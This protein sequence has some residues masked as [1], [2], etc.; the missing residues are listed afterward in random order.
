MFYAHPAFGERFYLRLL[1]NIV[2]GPK[3]Y[4]NIRTVDG[5]VY[6][7]YKETCFHR[8]LLES[9]KEWHIALADASV[10][11]SASQFRDLFVTLL[12]FCEVS[13]PLELW[14]SHWVDMADDIEYTRHKMT[15]FPKLKIGNA[16][17]EMLALEAVNELLKQYGKKV[18]DYPGLP[19]LRV[20]SPT[21]YKNELLM[22]KMMYDREELRLKA[23]EGGITAHSRFKIPIDADKFSC[24]EIKQ[25]TYLAELICNTS[26]VIW[27]EAPMT[28]RYVFEAVDRTFRD[29][30]SKVN[31]E[32]GTLPFGGLTM[33]LGGDFRQV[34]PVIPKKRRV[35]IVAASISKSDLL[36][37]CKVF[38]LRENMRIEIN[39]PTVTVRGDKVQFRD[40]VLALGDG[41]EE[42]IA[43]GDDLEPSWVSLP[44][45][46]RVNYSGDAVKAIVNEIY[47]DLHK[48]HGDVEY[49]RSRA[50]LTPLNEHIESVN[51]TV[52]QS[53][54]GEFKVYKSCDSICKG[55]ST[56]ESD[57]ILYPPGYLNSLKFSGMPNHEIKDKVGA[58]IML[59]R[60][61]NAKKGLCKGT[62]LII[63]RCYPFL[64][65][66][67][68]ITGNRIGNT[69]Y[70]PRITMCP[71][72]KTLPF[73][74]KRKQFPIAVCYAMTVNK[75]QGQTVQNVGL[76][77]PESI[78]GHGQ[79]YIA[80]SRVTSPKGLRIVTVDNDE[81]TKGYTKNIVYREVFDNIL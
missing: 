80:V 14:M 36:H 65:E 81:V 77:L 54:P 63:T 64:I 50:I 43:I 78:F 4:E 31:Q 10:C 48:K 79:L 15:N 9:D 39:V 44:E 34:L 57:E 53:L 23:S 6:P 66:A 12:V 49:L 58:P 1:L 74:L 40:W 38:T 42:T 20:V 18:V 11:A 32:A 76:Y 28:H 62:R 67:L 24:C 26:L 45:E 71:A 8:G 55:S 21:K 56:S 60:N 5:I 29:I 35:E 3:N 13:N 47:K 33:V 70:I 22:E 17:K 30:C 59:L 27:D 51:V 2:V 52:L 72:D 46:V 69:T 25:N 19:E 41:L 73:V 61:L 37:Y 75:S 16:D 68:I 7:T